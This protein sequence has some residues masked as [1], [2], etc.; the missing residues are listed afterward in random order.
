M[1]P[2]PQYSSVQGIESRWKS[3]LA[4]VV[5]TREKYSESRFP[6]Q[7]FALVDTRGLP[8]LRSALERLESVSFAS[9]W[10]ETEIASFSDIAPLLIDVEANIASPSVT[11]RLLERLWRFADDG[12]MVTWLWSA[13]SIEDLTKHL[14]TYCEYTLPDRRAFYLHFYD[15]RILDRLRTVWSSDE[16]DC[17][18][19]AADEIWYR[20]RSG[21]DVCWEARTTSQLNTPDIFEMNHEQH[22]ALFSLG[23]PDKLVLHLRTS[24]GAEIGHIES[25]E[26]YRLICNQIDRAARY[27]ISDEHDL[28]AY[29]THGVLISPTFD[30]HAL[31]HHHLQASVQGEMSFLDAL[32]RVADCDW[33]SIKAEHDDIEFSQTDAST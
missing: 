8:D 12:F 27:R 30:E 3:F 26:L 2:I 7:L 18:A 21:D 10:D 15:N 29:V 9:L 31:V 1:E 6:V 24:C 13:Q 25:S 33:S 32:K 20:H 5:K 4:R 16:W 14:R 11:D 22:A 23:Y 19:S 17:F 28:R